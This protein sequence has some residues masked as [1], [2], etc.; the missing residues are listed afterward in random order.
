MWVLRVAQ[1]FN[2]IYYWSDVL[3]L[4]SGIIAVA[5]F[6][7][8]AWVLGSVSLVVFAVALLSD[9]IGYIHIIEEEEDVDEDS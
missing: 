8:G 6:L 7:Y 3:L 4:F 2:F 5:A 9:F 1:V